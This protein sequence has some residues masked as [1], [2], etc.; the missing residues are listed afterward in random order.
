M[1]DP[2][3][4]VVIGM[5]NP[6]RRDD[7]VGH[8]LLDELDP[9]TLETD[10]AVDLVALDG[11]STRLIEA[12]R[13]RRRA[14]VVDAGGRG[15]APGSIHRLQVGLDELPGWTS[16]ASSHA[17]GLAEAVALGEAV[18]V[19]PEELIVLAVEPADMS[20]GE[21]LSGPVASAMPDLAE[22]VRREV[23]A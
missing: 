13:G 2:A 7:G 14:I 10:T 11:E 12:W 18:D 5:G 16:S 9:T 17:P 8:A 21:G 4:I 15:D 6:M 1:T 23:R 19:L 22:Q 3:P 20:P